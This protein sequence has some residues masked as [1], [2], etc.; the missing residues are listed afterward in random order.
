MNLIQKI[1]NLFK[2]KP[3]I[4]VK[5][6]EVIR[7]REKEDSALITRQLADE[8]IR[9]RELEEERIRKSW[10]PDAKVH[11]RLRRSSSKT[12]ARD[13]HDAIAKFMKR[14][15]SKHSQAYRRSTKHHTTDEELEDT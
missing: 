5:P 9:Q 4:I 13:H 8:I 14:S 2:R 12:P 6:V 7:K 1:I 15:G 11:R 3:K 10:L